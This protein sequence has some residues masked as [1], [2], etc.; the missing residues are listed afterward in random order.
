MR[1]YTRGIRAIPSYILLRQAAV[2]DKGRTAV[3]CAVVGVSGVLPVLVALANGRLVGLVRGDHAGATE[4]SA[5]TVVAALAAMFL[6]LQISAPLINVAAES[7]GRRVGDSLRQRMIEAMMRPSTIA[8]L[9]DAELLR[10][11]AVAQGIGTNQVEIHT[12]FTALASISLM[13]LQALASGIVLLWF[14]P[15]LGALVTVAYF[16][17]THA[18]AA[19]Y[20]NKQRAVYADSDRLRRAFY[21]RD[22]ALTGDAAQEVRVFGLADWL[23]RQFGAAWRPGVAHRRLNPVVLRI[24]AA[25]AVVVAAHA[26]VYYRLGESAADGTIGFSRFITFATAISG[27]AAVVALTMDLLYVREGSRAIPAA[28]A[29]VDTLDGWT[30]DAGGVTASD[31]SA[32]KGPGAG[33][34]RAP[35]PLIRFEGV[36]FRYPGN[37]T[38]AVRGLDLEIRPGETLAIVGF[39]GAGKTTLVKLLCGLQRPTE[40]RVTVGGRDIGALDP[41]AWQRHF[42]VVFQHFNRYPVSLADNIAFGAPGW[43]ATPEEIRASA[44]TAGAEKLA[45]RLRNGFET[46]L[47]RRY[48][49]GDDLSGG[50]W[51]RVAVARAVHAVR[52]GASCLVLDEPTSAL[53]ARA[54]ARFHDEVMRRSGAS[55]TILVSHRFATVRRADRIVALD[56]GRVA[57]DGT[58]EELMREEGIYAQMFTLQAERFRVE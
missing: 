27:L 16:A 56:G 58:H 45:G 9:E 21:V 8:P 20:R 42:A 25:C 10:R 19:E 6:C 28:L 52:A 46:V 12:A 55:A 22:L 4:R 54:E 57:E 38:W 34:V 2:V 17:L 1:Q 41:A 14:D 18:M 53:D 43:R 37:R 11:I 15:A 29:V 35:L 32:G 3:L 24:L 48:P 51:Q 26:L 33:T 50:Q 5:L 7:L 23:E 40:G 30:D 49:G 31:A 44:A 13:R 47:S 36:G 39:N